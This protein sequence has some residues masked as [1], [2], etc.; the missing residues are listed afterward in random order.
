MKKYLNKT[1]EN[2]LE[3]NGEYYVSMSYLPMI[4]DKLKVNIFEIENFL[5]W[6]TPE[7]LEEYIWYSNAFKE[8][9]KFLN[10]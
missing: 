2:N 7:D 1:I 9:T 4:K 3:T 8:K 10:H 6:G 5:Q